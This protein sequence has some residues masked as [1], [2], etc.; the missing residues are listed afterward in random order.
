M[1]DPV[2]YYYLTDASLRDEMMLRS[3]L[4]MQQR[5]PGRRQARAG[6]IDFTAPIVTGNC[7]QNQYHRSP[8]SGAMARAESPL[9]FYLYFLL[10]FS[11][12]LPLCFQIC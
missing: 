11:L 7:I 5:G 4:V 2:L 10:L 3:I 9:L 8:S 1:D 6:S 12:I